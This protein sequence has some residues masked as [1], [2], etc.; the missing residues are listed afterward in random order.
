MSGWAQPLISADPLSPAHARALVPQDAACDAAGGARLSERGRR[1]QGAWRGGTPRSG[2]GRAAAGRRGSGRTEQRDAGICRGRGRR[3]G[4][5]PGAGDGEG[6]GGWRG[7][8]GTGHRIF[9]C[10]VWAGG[11]RRPV[12][13]RQEA[14]SRCFRFHVAASSA[15]RPVR[16]RPRGCCGPIGSESHPA[17]RLLSPA[18][19]QLGTARHGASG[20]RSRPGVGR[21]LSAGPGPRS[22]HRGGRTVKP[23]RQ[24]GADRP[25][26]R[27]RGRL[28][29]ARGAGTR[30]RRRDGR[31]GVRDCRGGGGWRQSGRGKRGGAAE[32]RGS[33]EL[34]RV[35]PRRCVRPRRAQGTAGGRER[36]CWCAAARRGR[37]AQ[38]RAA[39]RAARCR[40]DAAPGCAAGVGL[41]CIQ[42]DAAPACRDGL[43]LGLRCIAASR[44]GAPSCGRASRPGTRHGVCYRGAP[45]SLL[46]RRATESVA[47]ARHGVCCRGAPRSLLPRRATESVTEA[48]HGVCYRGAPRSL[49]PRHATE[50][51][52]FLKS[53]WKGE[54][55][56]ISLPPRPLETAW[57]TAHRYSLGQ[58]VCRPALCLGGSLLSML[59][60]P[61]PYT[62]PSRCRQEMHIPSTRCCLERVYRVCPGCI[63]GGEGSSL[64]AARRRRGEPEALG[65]SPPVSRWTHVPPTAS[66]R[67]QGA[68]LR[69][70]GARADADA[71]RHGHT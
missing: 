21:F 16:P 26:G 24:P 15:G 54:A 37:A 62:R 13:P 49:L 57:A 31:V 7:G 46:P 9:G 39:A 50:S 14:R 42:P 45:R 28:V 35:A 68:P 5:W 43:L 27:P 61:F 69:G 25:R 20:S 47:E 66:H 63:L 18:H 19:P 58:G 12:R 44:R 23:Q 71:R 70:H 33:V 30:R 56:D 51:V 22:S 38:G 55:L 29:A 4:D 2:R 60:A 64:H 40:A 6:G 8:A 34:V 17:G 59:A 10:F 65:P 53:R 11:A 52:I 48:R 3:Q 67:R 32:Q 36:V 1:G 41:R